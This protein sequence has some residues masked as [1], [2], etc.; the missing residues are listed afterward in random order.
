[1]TAKRS[2]GS[3]YMRA[4]GFAYVSL[5]PRLGTPDTRRIIAVKIDGGFETFQMNG[6]MPVIACWLNTC[7][8][9]LYYTT[10]LVP[11]CQRVE[12]WLTW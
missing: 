2:S 4:F 10:N 11:R 6:P 8:D 5:I 3:T 1:M 12:V 7:Q 9:V